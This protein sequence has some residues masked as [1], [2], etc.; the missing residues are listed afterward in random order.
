MTQ[1]GVQ[2]VPGFQDRGRAHFSWRTVHGTIRVGV[3]EPLKLPFIFLFILICTTFVCA[4]LNVLSAWGLHESSTRI[5][6]L[7]YAVQRLP[8]S[9]YDVLVPS[10]V[11]SIVLVGFGWPESRLR[12]RRCSS[13]WASGTS[14]S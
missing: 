2:N 7:A 5:F 12:S 10:V 9:V 8:G 1:K 6:T 14:S 3:K 4:V 11:L 13:C